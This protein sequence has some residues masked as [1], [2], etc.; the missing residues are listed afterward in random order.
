MVHAGI[1]LI[2]DYSMSNSARN[3]D[4]IGR[5][6]EHKAS[7]ISHLCW[8]TLWLGFHTLLLYAHN[9]AVSAFGEADKQLVLDPIYGQIIQAASG[10]ASIEQSFLPIGPADLLAHHAIALG[11]HTTV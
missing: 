6:L 11:L 1:F 4:T 10:N 8:I 9:D 7:I 2:R 3:K 5:I